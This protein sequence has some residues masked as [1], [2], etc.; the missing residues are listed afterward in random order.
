[1]SHNQLND[2]NQTQSNAITRKPSIQKE[3]KELKWRTIRKSRNEEL[4]SD[5]RF[6]GENNKIVA[7]AT[8]DRDKADRKLLMEEVEEISDRVGDFVVEAMEYLSNDKK[9][10]NL[11]LVV[12][13]NQRKL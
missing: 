4:S 6:L 1:M 11:F 3:E 2:S 7:D 8:P 5:L 9:K 13:E 12:R 10:A